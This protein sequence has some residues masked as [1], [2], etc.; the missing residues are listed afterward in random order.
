MIISQ[1]IQAS[2]EI[3]YQMW[4]QGNSVVQPNTK[5]AN[6]S[7]ADKTLRKAKAINPENNPQFNEKTKSI[8]DSFFKD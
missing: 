6:A 2:Q 5:P 7:K 4:S 1:A 8:I 3:E